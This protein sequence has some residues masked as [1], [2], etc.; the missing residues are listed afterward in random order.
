LNSIQGGGIEVFKK[1]FKNSKG[2]STL[3]FAVALPVFF[4]FIAL[5]ID[6]GFVT[7]HMSKAQDAADFAVLSGVQHLPLDPVGA[8]IT[9]KDIF[10]DNYGKPKA[11]QNIIV[12]CSLDR[13][14]IDYEQEVKLFFLPIIGKDSVM[15]S[16]TSEATIEPLVR[17]HTM[18]PIAISDKTPFVFGVEIVLF[19][20]LDDPIRGNFG[21]VD[22]TNDNSL[23]PN[24]FEDLIAEDYKGEKGMPA[25]GDEIWTRPGVLGHRVQDGLMRR[26]ENGN[27]YITLPVVDFTNLNGR[28]KIKIKG[29]ARFKLT[30]VIPGDGRHVSIKGTFIEYIDAKGDGG[31]GNAFYYGI[32]AIRL[33]K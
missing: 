20:Q 23:N 7:Y 26:M 30:E 28:S 3:L 19:G 10:I 31:G 15:I 2:Q 5:A 18:I 27:Y 24:D 6:L 22:P 11:I 12:V 9:T 8:Q 21:L 17:P 14:K 33:K 16:G 13:V 32:K 29:Y 25:A 1:L 4:G